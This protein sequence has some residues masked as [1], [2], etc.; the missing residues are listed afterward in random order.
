MST[1]VTNLTARLRARGAL[2]RP[3]EPDATF[4]VVMLRDMSTDELTRALRGTGLGLTTLHGMTVLHRLP[5]PPD[6][7]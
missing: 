7:A 1:N 3:T 4:H 6:A 5:T 2:R